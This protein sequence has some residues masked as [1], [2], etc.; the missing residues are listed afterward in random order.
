[1][2]VIQIFCLVIFVICFIW[3]GVLS[4]PDDDC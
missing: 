4:M 3:L 1:M 2:E